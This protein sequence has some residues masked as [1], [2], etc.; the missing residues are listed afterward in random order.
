MERFAT[1][2]VEDMEEQAEK[3]ANRKCEEL[4]EKPTDET[5]RKPEERAGGRS[6]KRD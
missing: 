2:I 3:E 5:E 4:Q 1:R 6:M